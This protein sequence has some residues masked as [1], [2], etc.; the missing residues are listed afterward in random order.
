MPVSR[1]EITAARKEL[2]GDV[3]VAAIYSVGLHGISGP[4]ERFLSRPI[5]AI[6][7]P[8]LVFYNIF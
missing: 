6:K 1:T 8:L 3:R 4:M 7:G 2:V 5:Y